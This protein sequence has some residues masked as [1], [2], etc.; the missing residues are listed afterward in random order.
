[1]L[2]PKQAQRKA[3]YRMYVD[4]TQTVKQAFKS[5]T[6]N[7]LINALGGYMK[8]MNPPENAEEI[9]M[10]PNEVKQTGLLAAQCLARLLYGRLKGDEDFAVL[11]PLCGDDCSSEPA[12]P[13]DTDGVAEQNVCE[14]AGVGGTC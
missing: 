2:S 4:L 13:I 10:S 14:P 7:E 8:L 5:T 1:M 3:V 9:T 11:E 12:E 6:N